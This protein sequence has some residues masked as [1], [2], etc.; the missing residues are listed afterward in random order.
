ML[1]AIW[2]YLHNL[3]NVKNTPSW[4]FFTFFK[5]YKPDQI[6]QHTT[7]INNEP[8]T[9]KGSPRNYLV[10]FKI[11]FFSKYVIHQ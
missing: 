9:I 6:T 4:A 10:P 11:R 5:L 2:Y 1:C 3:K 8:K 7:C